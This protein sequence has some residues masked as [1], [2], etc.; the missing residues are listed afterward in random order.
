MLIRFSI[1]I[2]VLVVMIRYIY[3]KRTKKKEYFFT[4]FII[5]V[6]V[7]FICFALKKYELNLGMALGLFAIFGIL[8]YR[9]L[10]IEIRE[11]T[12]LFVIIGI[13]IINALSGKKMS[14]SE[15]L[16]TNA[17][18]TISLYLLEAFWKNNET[19]DKVITYEVI[20]NIRPESRHLLKADLEER[21]GLEILE[22]RVGNV[23]FLRDTAKVYISCKA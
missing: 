6:V 1:N 16:L 22:I 9:T 17:V 12:Y 18:I 14:Y 3:Y 23:N 7:F 2:T 11:M 20:K 8:R 15:I 19:I 13:S 21:L 5:G 10:P 4:F